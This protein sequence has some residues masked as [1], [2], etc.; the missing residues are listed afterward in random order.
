MVALLRLRAA[1][2]GEGGRGRREGVGGRVGGEAVAV[3]VRWNRNETKNR[4]LVR[5][6]PKEQN[7]EA[8]AATV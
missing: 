1:A 7:I 3:E 4:H 8:A 5:V 2:R 6:H